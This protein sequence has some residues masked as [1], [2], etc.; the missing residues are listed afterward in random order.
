MCAERMTHGFM[1]LV[2]ALDW[3]SCRVL[4]WAL[5]NTMNVAFC[6]VALVEAPERF[7]TPDILSTCQ[8]SR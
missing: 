5:T 2:A 7:G 4:S 8:G 6:V 3:F 1:Y